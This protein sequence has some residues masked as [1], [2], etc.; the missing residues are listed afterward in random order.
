VYD[1]PDNGAP[2]L[3]KGILRI[4]PQDFL[5]QLGTM[6][7]PGA[8]G[9]FERLKAVTRF[10]RFFMGTLFDLYAGVLGRLV[11]H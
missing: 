5:T 9:V 3:G 7:A 2:A 4:S 1:G 10:G 6:E 8:S 11:P